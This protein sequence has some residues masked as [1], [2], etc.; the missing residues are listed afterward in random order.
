[1]T[2]LRKYFG[3][4]Y[5][6]NR[7]MFSRNRIKRAPAVAREGCGGSGAPGAGL[8]GARGTP[9]QDFPGRRLQGF[10]ERRLQDFPERR[11]QGFPG[12]RCRTSRSAVCGFPGAPSAGFPG[13]RSGLFSEPSGA[14]SRGSFGQGPGQV[15]GHI[16]GHVPGYIFGRPSGTHPMRIGTGKRGGTRAAARSRLGRRMKPAQTPMHQPIG[17]RRKRPA[18]PQP[19]NS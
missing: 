19:N 13:R 3:F 14:P 16:F 10:P 1:M 6:N 17:S 11:L 9:L 5:S 4:R 2:N 7:K 12:R 15:S 18:G 8:R